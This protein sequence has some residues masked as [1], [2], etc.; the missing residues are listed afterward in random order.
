MQCPSILTVL[1][2]KIE[3]KWCNYCVAR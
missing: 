3:L 2:S 1:C